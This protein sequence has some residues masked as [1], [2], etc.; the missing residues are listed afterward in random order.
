MRS[1]P[2][3]PTLPDGLT[4]LIELIEQQQQSDQALQGIEADLTS[5]G[6]KLAPIV[7]GR[8]YR[9]IDHDLLFTTEFDLVLPKIREVCHE[10]L[11]ETSPKLPRDDRTS[12]WMVNIMT[13]EAWVYICS[14]RP[15][16]D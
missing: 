1:L 10:V 3:D 13:R 7:F 8:L 14:R 5:Y 6:K 11:Y 12:S 15:K 9:R 4:D 16:S 2:R